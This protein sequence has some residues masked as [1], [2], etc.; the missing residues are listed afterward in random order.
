MLRRFAD[1]AGAAIL[2]VLLSPFLLLGAAAVFIGSGRPIFF[3]H[4]R[5]GKAG[6]LFYCWKLRT[7]VAEA[8]SDLRRAP[9]LHRAYVENGF[10]LPN[11]TDPR[12]TGVGRWLRRTYVDEIPQLFNVLAGSMA[13][14]GPR[15]I[16]AEEL[17]HYGP[18]ADVLLAAKPGIVGAWTS[19]GRERPDYPERARIELDYVRHRTPFRDLSILL[20]TVPVVLRGQDE[21]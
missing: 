21:S 8:E 10:K 18:D 15:P 12:I 19:R 6:Q 20:R 3:R 9:L 5:V 16:V 14:V 11:H 2:L 13:L 4:A 17:L 1:V 7:M